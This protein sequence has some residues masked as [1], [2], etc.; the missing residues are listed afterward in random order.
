MTDQPI[1]TLD[2]E[3]LLERMESHLR[4]NGSYLISHVEEIIARLSAHV[5]IAKENRAGLEPVKGEGKFKKTSS[6]DA[7]GI[8]ATGS[9]PQAYKK[10]AKP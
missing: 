10:V 5:E 3:A 4:K 8:V 7:A 1:E 2:H 6:T 9:E